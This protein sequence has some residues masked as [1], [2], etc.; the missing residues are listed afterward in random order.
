LPG[1]PKRYDMDS[2]VIHRLVAAA[3]LALLMA[4]G[5]LAVAQDDASGLAPVASVEVGSAR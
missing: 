1:N 3:V 2:S 4:V 5:V